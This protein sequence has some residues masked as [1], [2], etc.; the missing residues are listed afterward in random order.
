MRIS[1]ED[2]NI[3]TYKTFS[4][5][6]RQ[7][8]VGVFKDWSLVNIASC[9]RKTPHFSTRDYCKTHLKIWHEMG[10]GGRNSFPLKNHV[11]RRA[12]KY[13]FF[14]WTLGLPPPAYSYASQRLRLLFWGYA[15]WQGTSQQITPNAIKCCSNFSL[16]N[17]GWFRPDWSNKFGRKTELLACRSLFWV[18]S[19]F[20]KES[21][22]NSLNFTKLDFQVNRK[23]FH[24]H[25]LVRADQRRK[26]NCPHHPH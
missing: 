4:A 10:H 12:D 23:T 15:K 5:A 8:Q 14:C 17:N 20:G 22:S 19:W 21:D 1:T 13:V 7:G 6:L 2:Q 18:S 16:P 11:Y 26:E 9:N 25:K 3:L 24:H